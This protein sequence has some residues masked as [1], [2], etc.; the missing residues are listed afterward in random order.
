[1]GKCR[2]KTESERFWEKVDKNGPVIVPELDECWLWK[3]SCDVDGYGD[4]SANRGKDVKAHRWSFQDANK[5]ILSPKICVLHRCDNPPCVRPSHL[6]SGSAKDNRADSDRKGRTFDLNKWAR[7]NRHLWTGR[8][9]VKITRQQVLEIHTLYR[10][11]KFSIQTLGESYGLSAAWVSRIVRGLAWKSFDL[12][13][14][15]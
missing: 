7:E 15:R 1:M 8:T 5:I 2:R 11:G 3:A 9:P 14:L 4:F 10:T 12:E 6:F 13:P